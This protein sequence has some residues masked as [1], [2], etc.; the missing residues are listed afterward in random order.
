MSKELTG[1]GVAIV[2]PFTRSGAVD[3]KSLENL[4]EH[5]IV[6]KVDFIVG[7]GTT[8]EAATL[9]NEEKAQ[10]MQCVLKQVE[11]RVPVV[12]GIGGNNTAE[13]IKTIEQTEFEKISGILSVAPYYNKPG[14]KGIYYHFNLLSLL[15]NEYLSYCWS[16]LMTMN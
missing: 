7:L 8:S 4:V 10:V 14:Q 5:I 6:N 15:R 1:T 12:I 13:V 3:F 9:S 16:E 11:E 2:T